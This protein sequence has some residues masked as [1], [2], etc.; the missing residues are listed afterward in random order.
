MI[1]TLLTLNVL[2]AMVTA[3]DNYANVYLDGDPDD[4][5]FDGGDQGFNSLLEETL[6]YVNSLATGYAIRSSQ[7]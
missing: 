3:G 2:R 6:Q 4:D 1:D 7:E 5:E